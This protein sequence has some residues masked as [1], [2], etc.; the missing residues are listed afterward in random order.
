MN[1]RTKGAA[2]ALMLFL[3]VGAHGEHSDAR[4]GI[5]V[6]AKAWGTAPARWTIYRDGSIDDARGAKVFDP[7]LPID[8][9][10]RHADAAAGRY[11]L[12]A[13]LLGPAYRRIGARIEC[14]V[15]HTDDVYGEI[16]WADGK[17]LP[18]A[19]GCD[20]AANRPILNSI[21]AAQA[22]VDGWILQAHVV[23]QYQT[24]SLAKA[25]EP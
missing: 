15:S 3:T 21:R 22:H 6:T 17:R 12:I 9:V 24:S 8:I 5:T 18:Y 16:T 13:R 14:V 4:S 2:V 23:R 20:D 11:A 25:D 19:F 10:Q 1:G 7:T